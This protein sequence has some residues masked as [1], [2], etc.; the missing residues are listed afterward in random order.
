MLKVS[1]YNYDLPNFG[2]LSRLENLEE[3]HLYELDLLLRVILSDRDPFESMTKLKNYSITSFFGTLFASEHY[4]EHQR[5][6]ALERLNV[7]FQ[8]ENDMLV[9]F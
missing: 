8:T 1:Y 2:N 3:V 6:C 9:I 7:D 5:V 4:F